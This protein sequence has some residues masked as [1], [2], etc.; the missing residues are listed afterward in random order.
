MKEGLGTLQVSG[1]VLNETFTFLFAE[2]FRPEGAALGKVFIISRIKS[3]DVTR[4]GK[5]GFEGRFNILRAAE[6]VGEII[7]ISSIVRVE[8]HWAVTLVVERFGAV[9]AVDRQLQIVGSQ[10]MSV[11]VCVRE[12]TTL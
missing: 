1:N 8:S 2:N 10:T 5:L 12:Q 11:C 3:G 4:D 9:G 6:T 7:G